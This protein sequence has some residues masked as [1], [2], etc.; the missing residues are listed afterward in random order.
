MDGPYLVCIDLS[1]GKLMWRGARYQGFTL[2][3]AD[4]D[5]ILVLTEKGE[6]ALVQASPLKFSE[7]GRFKALNGKTWSHPVLA[8]NILVVRNAQEMAAFRI[9]I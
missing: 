3:L 6:V 7:L 4:Q 2:L 5:L 9:P 8:G 1:N